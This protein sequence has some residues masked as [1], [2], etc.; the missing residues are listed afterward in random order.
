[1]DIPT[2]AGAVTTARVGDGEVITDRVG[3]GEVIMDIPITAGEAIT[4]IRITVMVTVTVME[5]MATTAADV[6][7][8]AITVMQTIIGAVRCAADLI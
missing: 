2:T 3:D 4:V 6:V 5:H 1:M 8:M 7:I